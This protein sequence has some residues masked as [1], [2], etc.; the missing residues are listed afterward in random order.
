MRTGGQVD[1][2]LHFKKYFIEKGNKDKI[3]IV[4]FNEIKNNTHS[5]TKNQF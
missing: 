5:G 2:Y 3:G 1:A 4:A